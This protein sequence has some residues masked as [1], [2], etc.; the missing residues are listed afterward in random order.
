[1]LN[2]NKYNEILSSGLLLDHY[3][4][5]ANIKNNKELLKNKRIQGFV[6]LLEKKEYLQEGS[7]TQKGLSLLEEFE[8]QV[9]DTENNTKTDDFGDWIEGLHKRCQEKLVELTGSKQV[10]D[11]ID[12]KS[13][14]FLPNVI[15]LGKVLYKVITTYKVKDYERIEKCI[16]NYIEKCAHAKSKDSPNGNW[17]PILQ[18]YILKNN[19]STLITDCESIDDEPQTVKSSQKFV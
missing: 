15:D 4:I 3:F 16:M 14:P 2:D 8:I 19:K 9:A 6:N 1:M 10:R 17:F 12:K 11:K 7:L 5:L 13:Y 18:Y